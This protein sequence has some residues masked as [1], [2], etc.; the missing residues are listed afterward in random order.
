MNAWKSLQRDKQVA[1]AK[2]SKMFNKDDEPSS[3][4]AE[5]RFE[6]VAALHKAAPR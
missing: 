6:T 3:S 2:R 5:H 1:L 4:V